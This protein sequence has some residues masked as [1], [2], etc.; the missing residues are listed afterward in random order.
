LEESWVSCPH[1]GRNLNGAQVQLR[2]TF[3]IL[4]SLKARFRFVG[5]WSLY[6]AVLLFSYLMGPGWFFVPI[7]ANFWV[8]YLVEEVDTAVKVILVS[9]FLQAVILL[10]LLYFSI[11]EILFGLTIISSYYT[12]QVPLGVAM[13]FVGATV[14]EENN[15]IIAVCTHFEKKMK[16]IIEKA[17]SKVRR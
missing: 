1:C 15:E 5:Y 2:I 8:G 6:L 9:S 3:D 13:S 16:Q 10:P 14:R 7:V 17:V 11:Y 4:T 12:L